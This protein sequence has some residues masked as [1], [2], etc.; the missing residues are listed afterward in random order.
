VIPGIRPLT[1]VKQA[2]SVEDFFGLEVDGDLKRG[3]SEA[4]T[5]EEAREFGLNYTAEMIRKLK[6]YEA[7]GVH[8]FVLNETELVDEITRR[9]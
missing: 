9:V 7:P 4:R 6:D 5:D 2:T 1:S 3:L 8:L